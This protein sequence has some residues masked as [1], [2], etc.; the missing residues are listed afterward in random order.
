M[1]H[2]PVLSV[3]I[4]TTI[5]PSPDLPSSTSCSPCPRHRS[6]TFARTH[7]EYHYHYNSFNRP[8][9]TTS[10]PP[11]PPQECNICQDSEC[12]NSNVILFCDMCNLAVHQECYGVP[13][14]PEG[15]WLC[16][17]C[18][19]SPSRPVECCLCPN[20]SIGAAFKRTED[21]RWAHVI[22]ALWIPEVCNC[23]YFGQES[24]SQ[25]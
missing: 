4:N 10:P 19:H 2:L 13:Y 3:N 18:L 14:V 11:S 9:I 25:L 22:C 12:H 20:G 1:Q 16:R 6:A 24:L 23:N 7:C 5:T 15:Q 21:A 8:P 17:R